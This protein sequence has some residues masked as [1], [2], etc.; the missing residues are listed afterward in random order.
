MFTFHFVIVIIFYSMNRK[1]KLSPLCYDVMK[2]FYLNLIK[3]SCK[4]ISVSLF[5]LLS[6]LPCV[7]TKTNCTRICHTAKFLI[8]LPVKIIK[9]W[10][11]SIL[12]SDMLVDMQDNMKAKHKLNAW[13]C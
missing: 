5:R 2:A 4:L 3:I 10:L 9:R 8:H 11:V 6:F 7:H 12:I 1:F 13:A